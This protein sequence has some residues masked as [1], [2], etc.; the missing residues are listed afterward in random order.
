MTLSL[1]ELEAVLRIQLLAKSGHPDMAT[2]IDWL[3]D[4]LINVYKE[5]PNMDFVQATRRYAR[6]LREIQ[7]L[8]G[9]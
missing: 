6:E 3:A 1:S 4:R 7:K 5:S 2:F 9:C 8:L